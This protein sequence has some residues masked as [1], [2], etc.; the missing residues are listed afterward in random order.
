MQHVLNWFVII[1]KQIQKSS[2]IDTSCFI[3][4][5]NHSIQFFAC[6]PGSAD[7]FSQRIYYRL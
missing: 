5:H 7:G 1:T 4:V 6:S 3:N 2:T